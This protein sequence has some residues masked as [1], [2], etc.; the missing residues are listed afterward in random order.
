MADDD[1][2]NRFSAR[3]AR[4]MRVGTNLGSIAARVASQRLFGRDQS[5]NVTISDEDD[6]EWQDWLEDGEASQE[7]SLIENDQMAKRRALMT[8]C[9]THLDQ[10]EQHILINR[11]LRDDPPTLDALSQEHGISRERVRQI[12]VRAFEK[13]KRIMRAPD[14]MPTAWAA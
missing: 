8:R 10:R 2:A 3:A 5:L 7:D 6:T 12:E 9:L 11:R 4:Y 1:E 13:L 14:N